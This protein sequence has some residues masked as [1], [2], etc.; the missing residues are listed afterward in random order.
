MAKKQPYCVVTF[1]TT[2]QAL[3]FNA[4]CD[5]H[6]LTGRLAPIPRQLSAGCGFAWIEPHENAAA[7]ESALADYELG[8]ESVTELEL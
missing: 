6:E 2:A 3:G 5:P 1:H 8:Y 4:S 7:L